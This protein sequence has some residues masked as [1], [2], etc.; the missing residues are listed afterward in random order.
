[1]AEGSVKGDLTVD[2]RHREIVGLLYGLAAAAHTAGWLGWLTGATQLVEAVRPFTDVLAGRPG[3]VNFPELARTGRELWA[4]SRYA[5]AAVRLARLTGH[6]RQL[7][8]PLW[9]WLTRVAVLGTLSAAEQTGWAEEIGRV[10]AGDGNEEAHLDFA[11]LLLGAGPVFP[12]VTR[13]TSNYRSAYGSAL[14]EDFDLMVERYTPDLRTVEAAGRVLD[15]L[16]ASLDRTGWPT[17][18]DAQEEILDLLA[19]MVVRVHRVPSGLRDTIGRYLN[20]RTGQGR[21][22]RRTHETWTDLIRSYV[23]GPNTRPT[24]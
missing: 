6:G 19:M 2:E 9:T 8:P 14:F 11:C 18:P 24:R 16:A 13:M 5:L 1:A 7:R 10:T 17:R 21:R 15:G 20:V 12:L 3:T 22:L 23:D 4:D